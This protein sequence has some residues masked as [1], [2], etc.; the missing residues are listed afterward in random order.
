MIAWEDA[1]FGF[2]AHL[3]LEKS[4][5]VNSVESYARDIEKL[6]IWGIAQGISSPVNFTKNQLL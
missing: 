4:L 1:K 2:N 3:Q 5:S 6:Q